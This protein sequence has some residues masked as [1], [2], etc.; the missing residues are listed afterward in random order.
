MAHTPY[1]RILVN[2]GD[3]KVFRTS[4]IL[5]ASAMVEMWARVQTGFPANEGFDVQVLGVTYDEEGGKSGEILA[6]ET[7][8]AMLTASASVVA[9]SYDPENGTN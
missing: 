6:T 7:I 3:A 1:F 2:Q 4:R 5:T 8:A 9:L